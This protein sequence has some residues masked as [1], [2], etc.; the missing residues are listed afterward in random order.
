MQFVITVI[1]R[2][3]FHFYFYSLCSNT[4]PG[5]NFINVLL[6]LFLPIFW[7][8]KISNPNHS[9]VLFGK[10]S[11][12]K[13]ACKMLM[14]LTAWVNFITICIRR[15]ASLLAVKFCVQ[16]VNNVNNIK[17]QFFFQ[18]MCARN[19]LFGVNFTNILRVR[20]SPI[21]FC[22]KFT[23]FRK[24]EE[25]F[26]NK[27]CVHKMLVKLTLC[28]IDPKMTQVTILQVINE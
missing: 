21:S 7:C 20:F 3:K 6:Q 19:F 15:K 13:C 16:V 11:Y 5:V 12:K 2:V 28:E 8:Q 23:N 24:A 26:A 9:F 27:K 1:I 25:Q 17:I 4:R 22:Q 14:R 18:N 10:I